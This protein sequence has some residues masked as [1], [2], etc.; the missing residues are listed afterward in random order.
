MDKPR[1]LTIVE[2]GE[3]EEFLRPLSV[4]CLPGVGPQTRRALAELGVRTIGDLADIPLGQ[5]EARF[6]EHGRGLWNKA[7]GRDQSPVG[8]GD[9]TKSIGHEHT[10]GVD[11]DDEGR[12]HSTLMRLCEKTA[13]RMR[14]AGF[15]GRTVT[16]KVRTEDFTTFTRRQTL[17]HP[18]VE[19]SEIYGAAAEN[20]AAAPV[21][22][23]R[24]RLIG[25]SVSGLIGRER[26][27]RQA[28]LFEGG[29]GDIHDRLAR[30]EDAVKDRFGEDAL[31]RGASFDKD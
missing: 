2:P 19:A 7:H 28:L 23:C 24:L 25:V 29:P 8:A 16:T 18:V 3:V 13:R 14:K 6:G 17:P 26:A 30:A 31:R 5:L 1:G 4:K 27:A 11:T 9:D 12:I 22:G 20:L 15:A 10:F 21:A